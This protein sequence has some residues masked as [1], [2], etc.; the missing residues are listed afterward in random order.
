MYKLIQNF[1]HSQTNVSITSQL[2]QAH[3]AH[4]DGLSDIQGVSCSVTTRLYG[5]VL[6]SSYLVGTQM[7]F[8]AEPKAHLQAHHTSGY[9]RENIPS[10][11][12]AQTQQGWNSLMLLFTVWNYRNTVLIPTPFP[13]CNL[14]WHPTVQT[15][16]RL[17]L[18]SGRGGWWKACSSPALVTWSRGGARRAPDSGS[19]GSQ[20]RV[21]VDSQGWE[22]S[23]QMAAAVCRETS[24]A[25]C[26]KRLS[27][28]K[29]TSFL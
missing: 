22:C 20:L 7:Y 6:S 9:T 4:R 2:K 1:F 5:T 14:L 3:T 23:L 25:S 13:S 11:N 26:L 12:E 16:S 17:I 18:Q 21:W 27:G 15:N 10:S 29:K 8:T 24:D 28:H 19:V